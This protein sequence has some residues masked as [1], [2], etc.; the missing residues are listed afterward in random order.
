WRFLLGSL[1]VGHGNSLGREGPTVHLSAAIAS[2]IGRWTFRDAARVQSML[3]VGMAAG[4]AAAFNAPLSALTFV[5]EELL[6]NFSMKAL[7]GMV[8]AVVVAAAVSRT[9][10][11]EEPVLAARIAE[12]YQTSAWMLVA[13]PL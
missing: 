9:I 7:G 3:P 12:D 4:I 13:L 11:G 2:R 5:F 1:Y 8:L 6:D 10:L